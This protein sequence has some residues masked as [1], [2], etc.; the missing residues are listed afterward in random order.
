MIVLVKRNLLMNSL[1]GKKALLKKLETAYTSC[2]DCGQEY[3]VYSV[4]CSSVWIGECDVCGKESRVTEARDF[5]YFSK[6]IR[7][8]KKEIKEIK[9][10]KNEKSNSQT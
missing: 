9:E 2:L 5:G 1:K 7:Q 8:L 6:Q 10:I 4:G 3:G